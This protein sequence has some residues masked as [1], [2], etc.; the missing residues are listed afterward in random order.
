MQTILQNLIQD[1][2]F[3]FRQLRRAPGFA[4]TAILTFAL[5]IGA[6][7][8]IFSLLD[9]ALLRSLPVHDPASL[10]TLRDSGTLW[11]GSVSA[12]GGTQED[13]F[14]YPMY[15]DLRDRARGFSGL[16]ASAPGIVGFT[17]NNTAQSLP[18]ELVTGN[19]F[20]VL[21]LQPALG[22]TLHPSD[23]AAPNANPV[24]VLS[25]KFWQGKLASDPSVLNSTV[26]INGHPF[27]IV[28]VAAPHFQSATWGQDTSIFLPISMLNQAVPASA[29]RLTNR[30]YKWINII[31][32]LA[33][34]T[35]QTQAAVMNAP[36]WHALRA[37][38]LTQ[39]KN[40]SKR[41]AKGFLDDS[42]LQ[43]LPG[44]RGFS[45]NRDSLQKP[46]L[47]V[48]AMAVLVLL[49]ASVN[50]ASLL[51]VRSA[52]RVREFSLR[53]ALGASSSRLVSQLLI[54]GLLI[55]LFGGIAGLLLAPA[56]LYVLVAQLADVGG[57]TAF[58]SSLDL[59]ILLFNF[60]IAI[61][62]SLLFSL[63]PALQMRKPNLSSTLRES[64]G[65]QAGGLLQLR[66]VVVCLQIGLSVILLVG[67]GLFIRT[68]QKLRAVDVGFNTTHLVTFN[69]DPA[70]A[71]YADAAIP[72][73]LNRV[74][75]TLAALPGVA[76]VGTTDDPELADNNSYNNITLTGYTPPP[77]DSFT[78]EDATVSPQYF[79]TMQVPLVAGRALT[80][81]D[82]LTH[83][84][85]ALVNQ[86][87]IKHFCN[88]DA[89]ACLGRHLGAG[90]GDNVKLDTEIVG[91]VHD[92]RHGG[93]RAEIKAAYYAPFR[94]RPE[95]TFFNFY[96]RT[97]GNPAQSE[98]EVRAAM[99]QLDPTLPL[100][101]LIT[102]EQQIDSN[103][104]N[105]RLITLLATAF[106]L[107]A[108]ILA[109]V[110][111]YGVLAYSTT[112]RTR[113]IGI[114]MALGSTRL[115][116]SQLIVA[117]VLKLAALGLLLA[118]PT[119]YGLSL[120]LRSQLFGVTAAD[121]IILLSVIALIVLVALLAAFFPA[122]R[123]A[124]INPTVALRTE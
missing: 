5:G 3:A 83:P 122:R 30:T 69:I 111:L 51:L 70:R 115:A 116:V 71:G 10:V 21:G 80:D 93:I 82:D 54:E 6:N 114:R 60:A 109:G 96:L 118:L 49:I 45:F 103:L 99:H 92:T 28:G 53:A 47:A 50:V 37:Y 64:T 15:R 123:A 76:S 85:V 119:A 12:N 106:G 121:P 87:F 2:T 17:R 107:L 27:T 98:L 101:T 33:P 62:V 41:F 91:V 20:D 112:Q 34:G 77:D 104:Q 14:S 24:A 16:V 105:E 61:A 63:V 39:Q 65:T 25:Y 4:L 84:H 74:Q 8:A 67:A 48:M 81:A 66:R 13:Y 44:S 55:G 31:G 90:G 88:G 56:A 40:K 42:H 22:R 38:E 78:V 75:D 7:T 79:S 9:Q 124:T 1:L 102:M 32:R 46:F 117:D 95:R 120:L 100:G 108:T 18:D 94:Q 68:M 36:L 57:D 110:G 43:V 59:R 58:T 86:A 19:Y 73:L 23:D 113:E 89:A 72:A 29:D 11:N 97:T 52:A 26:T 35:T